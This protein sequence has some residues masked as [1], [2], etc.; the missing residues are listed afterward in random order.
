MQPLNSS[1]TK[2]FTEVARNLEHIH[3]PDRKN[4]Q[5]KM[6]QLSANNSTCL[7]KQTPS[8]KWPVLIAPLQPTVAVCL[9]QPAS[10]LNHTAINMNIV[11]ALFMPSQNGSYC[12][13]VGMYLAQFL[14]MAHLLLLQQLHLPLVL[15]QAATL[16]V[17]A[18]HLVQDTA[19]HPLQCYCFVP[20]IR[21]LLVY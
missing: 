3:K 15:C 20:V 10:L 4:K 7:S 9:C 8:F 14:H 2:R 12:I 21:F 5:F 1:F 11:L 16:L 19:L 17:P 18:A 6:L 13:N